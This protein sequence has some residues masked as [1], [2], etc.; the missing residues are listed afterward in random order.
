MYI[1]V[2]NDYHKSVLCALLFPV[3][4]M[5]INVSND[6]HL[7]APLQHWLNVAIDLQSFLSTPCGN[8]SAL[9]CTRK[10]SVY[11][12]TIYNQATSEGCCMTWDE[13]K[14]KSGAVEIGSLLFRYLREHVPSDV[15]HIIIMSDSIMAQNRNQYIAALLF[16]AVQCLPGIETIEQTFLEPGIQ[17]WR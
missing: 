14:R 15:K 2:S 5:C 9:Y 6:Y 16:I 1:I 8:V 7:H 11:N 10:I 4:I 13:T 12:F 17:K 3:I